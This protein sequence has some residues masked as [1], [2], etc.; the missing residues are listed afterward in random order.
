MYEQ[1]RGPERRENYCPAHEDR[2]KQMEKIEDLLHKEIK[3]TVDK[4][5]GQ[6]R[7]LLLVLLS[8]LG[9]FM[10]LYDRQATQFLKVQTDL[11][12]EL[13][14]TKSTITSMDKTVTGYMAAHLEQSKQGFEMIKQNRASIEQN[15]KDIHYLRQEIEKMEG[16]HFSKPK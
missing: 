15:S 9:I 13:K 7:I 11:S 6:W 3:P 5:T 4:Q 10:F 14:E 12:E 1:Q 2:A 16:A 8:S